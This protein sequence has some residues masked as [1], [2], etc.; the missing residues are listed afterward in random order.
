MAHLD[1][2][3]VGWD[4]DFKSFRKRGIEALMVSLKSINANA[5][6][7]N[8]AQCNRAIQCLSD[9]LLNF[10]GK[11]GCGSHYD[12][13]EALSALAASLASVSDDHVKRRVASSISKIGCKVSDEQKASRSCKGAI[14]ALIGV[15]NHAS[16]SCVT[17]IVDAMQSLDNSCHWLI[18]ALGSAACDNERLRI[19][20]AIVI[21]TQRR[22][23][24]STNFESSLSV[25]KKQK[26]DGPFSP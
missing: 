10:I 12:A 1:M 14:D 2:S 8:A 26:I 22:L 20:S 13:F 16:D 17:D 6:L 25:N 3:E 23:Q 15:L 5:P 21:I 7:P 11:A 24:D 19:A 4:S 18:E 9:A